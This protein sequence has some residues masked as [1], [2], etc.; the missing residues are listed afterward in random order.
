MK[1]L[2]KVVWSEGMYLT[3]QHFQAQNRYFEDSIQFAL[4]TLWRDGYG[5]T[6]YELDQEAVRNGIVALSH[7]RGIFPDGVVFDMPECDKLPPP[8]NIGSA[9]P[10]VADSLMI[11]LVIPPWNWG[12]ANCDLEQTGRVAARYRRQSAVMADENSGAD[13]KPVTIG[14]KNI[15]L[16]FE[17]ERSDSIKLPI[18]RVI[19]DGKG[20][21]AYDPEFIPPCTKITASESLTA[22]ARRLL[23]ILQEKS[24]MVSLGGNR[25]AGQFQTGMSANQV[26]QFWFLH[27]IN[28]H[29][30]PLGH[31]LSTKHAHPE[32]LYRVLLRLAG[33]L[34][35]F[36]VDS[37]P[38][39]LPVYDHG[40]PEQ[41]FAALD[42][43]IRRHLEIVLPSR[44]ITIPLSQADRYLYES[45]IKDS[46]CFG[47]SRWILGVQAA[48]GEAD[49]ISG[50]P[51]YMKV[52]SAKFVPELVKRAV[53]GMSLTHLSVPPSAMVAK[54]E[55]QYFAIN[56][57]GPCWEHILQSKRIGVYVP[58]EFPKA[59]LELTVILES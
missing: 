31:I 20:H 19:R 7:A 34:C 33:A 3:P 28:S 50:V 37:H 10:A 15:T 46:R 17:S 4:A 26:A 21:F 41:C 57:A 53:P 18:A 52:C 55:S 49:L 1:Q 38:R 59:E 56:K 9:F 47:R 22:L 42:Q 45:E 5:L 14:Q 8:R 39:S 29:L 24:S 54:V 30:V 40:Q 44:A 48:I 6:S 23:D 25:S 58:G 43:H 36:G 27:T 16:Q 51:Q 35:T 2:S 32:E 12:G 13:E 11:F